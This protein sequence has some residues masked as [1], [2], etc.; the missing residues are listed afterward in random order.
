MLGVKCSVFSSIDTAWSVSLQILRSTLQSHKKKKMWIHSFHFSNAF[1]EMF[2][3]VSVIFLYKKKQN[4]TLCCVVFIVN[5]LTLHLFFLWLILYYC[6]QCVLESFESQTACDKLTEGGRQRG[7]PLIYRNISKA[8]VRDFSLWPR[9]TD[10]LERGCIS[11]GNT[12]DQTRRQEM[13]ARNQ[14]RLDI[15]V[16]TIVCCCCIDYTNQ[17]CVE[18]AMIDSTC[19]SAVF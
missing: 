14:R 7:F 19:L 3:F 1:A 13:E 15:A 2:C 17:I 16:H 8:S 10:S 4:W 9:R 12:E 6:S 11:W 5:C 18:S